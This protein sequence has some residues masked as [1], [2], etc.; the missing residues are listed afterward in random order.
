[1]STPQNQTTAVK[2]QNVSFDVYFHAYSGGPLIDADTTPTFQILDPNNFVATT[3]L[4]VWQSTGHYTAYWT[5]PTTALSSNLWKVK[6]TASIGGVAV[7]NSQEYFIVSDSP[8]PYTPELI[9]V[10]DLT[11]EKI[12]SVIGYPR[13]PKILFT[14]DEIKR[15]CIHGALK[16]YFNKFPK[17]IEVQAPISDYVEVDF[18]DEFTFGIVGAQVVG[19]GGQGGSSDSFWD[20]VRWQIYSGYSMSG[21]YGI[22]R[23]NPNGLNDSYFTRNLQLNTVQNKLTTQDM[24]L[25]IYDRKLRVHS[26]VSGYLLIKWAKFS[27]NFA[28]VKREYA[29]DVTKLCQAKLLD[30]TGKTT[31]LLEDSD[32][33]VKFNPDAMKAEAKELSDG[34]KEKWDAIIAPPVIYFRAT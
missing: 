29:E 18:P 17:V 11:L 4:G 7:Q 33:S 14:D 27:N 22:N 16:E 6:W 24:R 1:M 26:G 8:A 30:L 10:D 5:V 12:K 19:K 21:N 34:V 31:G 20:V 3:G 23:F 9:T 15:L 28:D 32:L 13:I 25:N 2:G